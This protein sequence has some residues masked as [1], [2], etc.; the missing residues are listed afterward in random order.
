[1]REQRP[2]GIAEEAMARRIGQ[3]IA[4][5]AEVVPVQE[6]VG[7]IEG[8][9]VA[10]L[11]LQRQL[12]TAMTGLAD[13]LCLIAGAA[14]TGGRGHHGGLDGVVDAAVEQR[15]L[16]PGATPRL[17]TQADFNMVGDFR[18]QTGIG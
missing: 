3:Q 11:L 17:A 2:V 16:T 5:V 4:A 6:G 1:M 8:Q 14:A 13:V 10:E 9:A 7:R 18:F 15:R 12:D